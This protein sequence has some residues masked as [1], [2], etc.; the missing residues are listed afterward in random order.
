MRIP[1]DSIADPSLLIPDPIQVL[2]IEDNA[3][4]VRL[5]QE[6]LRGAGREHVRLTHVD[7]LSSA[8]EHLAS[9]KI[10]AILLD[11]SLPDGQGLEGMMQI[12]MAYPHLPIVVL[13]GDQDDSLALKALGQGAQDYLKKGESDGTNLIRAIRYAIERQ[14]AED[15]LAYLATHD[16]LTGLANRTLLRDRLEHAL[17]RARRFNHPVYVLYLDLDGFKIANDSYGH[18]V[19]DH[20]LQAA[21]DRLG[22]CVRRADTAARVGGDEFV[23][24]LEATSRVNDI[25]SIAQKIL[26][27]LARPFEIQEHRILLTCSIGLV[28]FP[29]DGDSV[30]QLLSHADTA[31]YRA[32]EAGGHQTMW[33]TS[34]DRS[35]RTVKLNLGQDFRKALARNE[36][37]VYYQPQL[38][39]RTNTVSS[40]KALLR[41]NHPSAGLLLP[42]MFVPVAEHGGQ[43]P[44]VEQWLLETAARQYQRW[45]DESIWSFRLCMNIFSW[46]LSSEHVAEE[47]IRS[48]DGMGISPA[49][50]AVELPSSSIGVDLERGCSIV[51]ALQRQGIQIVLAN[52]GTKAWSLDAMRRLPWDILKID[53]SLVQSSMQVPADAAMVRMLMSLGSDLRRRVVAEGVADLTQ[54]KH[55]LSVGCG[56]ATGDLICPPMS[57][58]DMTYW[59]TARNS[60]PAFRAA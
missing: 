58:Q 24:I 26:N 59:L 49:D 42:A 46:R 31:M 2:L 1:I 27:S 12:H 25:E 11:L 3:A 9:E 41:W 14:R 7:R 19:G 43:M 4:D 32:K 23:V 28:G 51:G 56:E 20:L 22:A 39:L 45:K 21:A 52:V 33:Y 37:V 18:T 10:D 55:L 34:P 50:V 48:I 30:D 16:P 8:V 54:L 5:A 35:S 44:A 6:S 53:P 57:D 15:R 17:A 36:L 40:V 60:P 29:K 38:N 13:S 47:F